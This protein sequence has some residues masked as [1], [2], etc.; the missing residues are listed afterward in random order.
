MCYLSYWLSCHSVFF[1]QFNMSDS[2]LKF[3]ELALV[4][5][6]FFVAKFHN[7]NIGIFSDLYV[8]KLIYSSKSSEAECSPKQMQITV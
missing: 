4:R 3:H 1:E 8:H 2:F 5:C 7:A 6:I